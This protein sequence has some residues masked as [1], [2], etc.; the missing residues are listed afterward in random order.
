MLPAPRRT[1]PTALPLL[2]IWLGLSG[3][4]SPASA[5][6]VEPPSLVFEMNGLRPRVVQGGDQAVVAQAAFFPVPVDLSEVV[7]L[8]PEAVP[9]ANAYEREWALSMIAADAAGT[10]AGLNDIGVFGSG[11]GARTATLVTSGV[12]LGAGVLLIS[13]ATH[14][15]NAALQT[16]NSAQA[17]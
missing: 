14:H 16:H 9:L 12:L 11:Q 1:D 8:T 13:R 15:L 3:L 5:Q 17:D 2:A 4:S 7:R 6:A 10:V